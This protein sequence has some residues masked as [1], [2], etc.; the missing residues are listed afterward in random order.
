MK[1]YI[2]IPSATGTLPTSMASFLMQLA[3]TTKHDIYPVFINRTG[4][5][6]ARNKFIEDFL[7]TDYDYLLFLDD[8][9]PPEDINFLDK[10]IQANKPVIT[11]LIP[12]RTPIADW[13]HFLCI[14]T[15]RI[16]ST[17]EHEYKQYVNIP[18]WPEIFEVANCGMWCVLIEREVVKLI[19]EEFDR[20]C[21]ARMVWYYYDEDEKQWIRDER[22]DYDKL[23][24]WMKRFKRYMSEDLLFFERAK[25][26]GVKIYAH[27]W[28][29]CSH[30]GN[31]E[32]IEVWKY[33]ISNNYKLWLVL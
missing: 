31:P 1:I 26:F 19:S 32:I 16:K 10:L 27:K 13:T 9:N 24:D 3:K 20:P 15:E 2:A 8:D 12:S 25:E 5:D 4:I 21:E 22:C 14:F 23:K 17:W 7:T 11:W 28:V 30:I 29:R 18:E 6:Q 33:I